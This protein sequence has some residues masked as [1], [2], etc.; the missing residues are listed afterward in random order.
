MTKVATRPPS[1]SRLSLGAAFALGLGTGVA[2]AVAGPA[3]ATDIDGTYR[4]L[5]VFGQVLSYVQANYVESV[6]EEK[7]IY[8]A[9]GGMLRDLD[10]HST[11]MRPAEYLKLREDTAGEFGGL[12]VRLTMA[13]DG[14]FID[15]V[16]PDGA[17]ERAG[18]LGGDRIVHIDDVPIK[19][20]D[21]SEVARRLRGVPG[22][23]VVLG[24]HRAS[25]AA[26]RDVALIRR[27]VRV[28]SVDHRLLSERIGYVRIHSFQERT[29]QELLEALSS[30]KQQLHDRSAGALQGL[31]L[32]LRDNPGGL[33][34]EGVKV[35][36]RFLRSGDIV[37]TEGRN[38]RA[39]EIQRAHPGGTEPEY[40]IAVLINR[41]SASASEIVAGALQDHGRARLVGTRSYGKGSVQT[42]FGLDDGSGL[43]LT[44]ARYYTPSG[45]SI[46][47]VGI[48]PDIVIADRPVEAASAT[49]AVD[50]Q[51]A[52]AVEALRMSG[53]SPRRP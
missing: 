10:P 45:R 27:F 53:S 28:N 2:L 33:L 12:G 24:L 30:L 34:D 6:P 13:D 8:D 21:V 52:A 14:V 7:L 31:V 15:T 29:D 23:R 22:T 43:K 39:A 4:K 1:S 17:A 50:P 48:D 47:E 51:L 5:R 9:I 38:P 32:D 49:D 37:R 44:I 26:P 40:P 18:V 46:Q 36:D 41:G 19:G 25:W 35:A 3:V 42:L 16:T 20:L 11:F